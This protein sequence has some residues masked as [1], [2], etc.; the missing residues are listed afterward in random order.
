[1]EQNFKQIPFIYQS[2]D[3]ETGNPTPETKTGTLWDYFK[4]FASLGGNPNPDNIDLEATELL[5]EFTKYLKNDDIL[6]KSIQKTYLDECSAVYTFIFEDTNYDM[7]IDE[8]Q[9]PRA[10]DS[11]NQEYRRKWLSDN[12][13]EYQ[14]YFV[15][16][17]QEWNSSVIFEPHGSRIIFT[18]S[19]NGGA[20]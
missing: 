15:D 7:F 9:E 19:C 20:E 14:S 12:I 5:K 1:M 10:S 13:F 6:V 18:I 4:W 17:Y 2:F 8:N 16:L 11:D 3:W